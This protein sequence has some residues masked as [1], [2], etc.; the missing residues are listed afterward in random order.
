MVEAGITG[1]EPIEAHRLHNVF[2]TAI[3]DELRFTTRVESRMKEVL[4]Q[5]YIPEVAE[6]IKREAHDIARFFITAFLEA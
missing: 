1:L 4:P 3:R 6:V 5:G 2:D